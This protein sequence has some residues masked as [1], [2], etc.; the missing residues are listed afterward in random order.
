[1]PYDSVHSMHVMHSL[2]TLIRVGSL[3][4]VIKAFITQAIGLYDVRLECID[5]IAARWT[6]IKLIS[7]ATMFLQWVQAKSFMGNNQFPQPCFYCE[8]MCLKSKIH[9]LWQKHKCP[10][11]VQYSYVKSM[12]AQT[13]KLRRHT[14]IFHMTR[15]NPNFF[16]LPGSPLEN[17]E[18]SRG[19]NLFIIF[20][21]KFLNLGCLFDWGGGG[22]QSTLEHGDLGQNFLG[23]ITF[24]HLL[25]LFWIF[26]TILIW[27]PWVKKCIS[28]F[29][30][31]FWGG[32]GG[33]SASLLSS[34]LTIPAWQCP[35]IS[36]CMGLCL[37]R[38]PN[39]GASSP[40]PP[41]FLGGG[42]YILHLFGKKVC[43]F[44]ESK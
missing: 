9:F 26:G 5:L 22:G 28:S 41:F 1:M 11:T 2:A 44:E 23:M 6:W 25:V 31:F 32:G 15:L 16:F 30:F 33:G 4:P 10:C 39:P 21:F 19:L 42:G 38:V 18:I 29:S 7:I 43:V 13:N 14:Q 34:K 3:Q 12:H 24:P 17:S 20:Y 40:P 36:T 27:L 8:A 37:F 35:Q